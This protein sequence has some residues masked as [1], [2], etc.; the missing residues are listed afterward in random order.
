MKWILFLFVFSFT[1]HFAF[2]QSNINWHAISSLENL[3][4]SK[5]KKTIIN[6]GQ[7]GCYWCKKMLQN[8]YTDTFV[9]KEA[10]NYN[11]ITLNA[12]SDSIYYQ[13]KWYVMNPHSKSRY[14]PL[15]LSFLHNK[16]RFPSTVFLAENLAEILVV[17]GYINAEKMAL[18]MTFFNEAYYKGIS[19][20][21]FE[22]SYS[23]NKN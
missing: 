10:V 17:S 5:T 15:A 9:I 21:E 20:E 4:K 19:L 23:L 22:K 16:M 2:S 13:N 1:H 11:M 18:L 7:K 3:Q 12:N 8:T 14:N 6:I